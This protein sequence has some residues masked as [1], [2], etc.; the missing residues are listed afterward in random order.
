MDQGDQSL[1][2]D[3]KAG[4][5]IRLD[6]LKKEAQLLPMPTAPTAPAVPT[7]KAPSFTPPS[8]PLNVKDLGKSMI[9][10]HEVEGKSYTYALPQMPKPPQVPSPPAVPGAP[11]LP[12]MPASPQ[13][14]SAPA[15]PQA[16]TPPQAPKIQTLEVWTS[17]KLQLPMATRV[18]GD[19]GKQTTISKQ[20]IPGE[21]PPSTF[22]IP[23]G[24][25]IVPPHAPTPSS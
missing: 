4:Q 5:T 25:K 13:P 2:T 17:P 20:V 15:P 8:P 24:Y 18:T 21:P 16:P 14:P 3:P 12:K 10:G 19:L 6:H 1:I 9:S 11:S 7:A 23:P 22:Q